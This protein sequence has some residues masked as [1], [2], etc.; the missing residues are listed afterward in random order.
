MF[1]F[2]KRDPERKL[3]ARIDALYKESVDAQ[4]NGKLR[5]YGGIM[6]EIDQL[7]KQLNTGEKR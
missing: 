2:L 5:L 7:Q 4:R 1:A 3:K 6:T